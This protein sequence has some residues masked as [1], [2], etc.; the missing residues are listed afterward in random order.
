MILDVYS[1][2]V[3]ICNYMRAT[4]VILFASLC[5]DFFYNRV[6][7]RKYGLSIQMVPEKTS[8]Y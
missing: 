3:C 5:Y 1:L 6:K 4:K 8:G 2:F 7:V